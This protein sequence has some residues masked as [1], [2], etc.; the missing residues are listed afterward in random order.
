MYSDYEIMS[1]SHEIKRIMDH[2]YEDLMAASGLRKVELD[3]LCFIAQAGEKDTARDI[4]DAQHI[5]KAHIS[6]SVD[7]LRQKGYILLVEDRSDHRK[8]HIHITETGRPVVQEFERIHKEVMER[9]FFNV[10]EEERDC[11][12]R[13]VH[14]LLANAQAKQR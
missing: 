12:R 7:N 11:M 4:I 6:K 13:I 1:L 2:A 5:S 10:E 9:L 14:K 8:L 3:I